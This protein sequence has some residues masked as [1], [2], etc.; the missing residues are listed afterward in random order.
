MQKLADAAGD[1]MLLAGLT[2]PAFVGYAIDNMVVLRRKGSL[3]ADFPVGGVILA[4][5]GK[6]A[7]EQRRDTS[8]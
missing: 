6:T 8:F 7:S 3:D 1:G 5:C 4:A 2:S